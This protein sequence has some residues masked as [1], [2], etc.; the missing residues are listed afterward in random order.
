MIQFKV[1]PQLLK[2]SLFTWGWGPQCTYPFINEL[3]SLGW[4]VC[5]RMAVVN[6]FESP[7][8]IGLILNFWIMKAGIGFH[9]N[10]A[11]FLYSVLGA[12]QI[13]IWTG[14]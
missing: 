8:L 1:Q 2:F 3:M 7:E 14:Q 5:P 10:W 12:C 11:Q 13:S 9:Y 6:Y 4:S